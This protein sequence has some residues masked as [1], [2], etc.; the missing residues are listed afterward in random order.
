MHNGTA[1]MIVLFYWCKTYI[2]RVSYNVLWENNLS[3]REHIMSTPKSTRDGP[4]ERWGTWENNLSGK[5]HILSSPKSTSDS[6]QERLG[7]PYSVKLA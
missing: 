1:T 5:E 6:P 2:T 4:Q 3:G 7:R